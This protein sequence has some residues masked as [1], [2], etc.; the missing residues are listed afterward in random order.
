MESI[1]SCSPI[2]EQTCYRA[3]SGQLVIYIQYIIIVTGWF[4]YLVTQVIIIFHLNVTF[5]DH[6]CIFSNNTA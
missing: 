1:I 4:F 3:A 2:A 5:T 6:L